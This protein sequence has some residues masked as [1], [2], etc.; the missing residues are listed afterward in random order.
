MSRPY[1][2]FCFKK[3]NRVFLVFS[4]NTETITGILRCLTHPYGKLMFDV[5][6]PEPV[7]PILNGQV[8]LNKN[9]YSDLH[10]FFG[11][12]LKTLVQ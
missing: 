1:V 4:W 5:T 6:F 11:H 12:E 2:S 10:R 9:L 7:P 8:V 3:K